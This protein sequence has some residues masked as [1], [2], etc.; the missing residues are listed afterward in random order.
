VFF[1]VLTFI[2]AA[3]TLRTRPERPTKSSS[4]NCA[5]LPGER[6]L[7]FLNHEVRRKIGRTS[8]AWAPP[9][10]FDAGPSAKIC[11]LRTRPLRMPTARDQSVESARKD[12]L[13]LRD[14]SQCHAS[15]GGFRHTVS[16]LRSRALSTSEANGCSRS[17]VTTF[18][19]TRSTT[20]RTLMLRRTSSASSIHLTSPAAA[21]HRRM[22][23]ASAVPLRAA[24]FDMQAV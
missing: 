13:T 5:A 4:R 6:G 22:F 20:A 15:R 2:Y 7:W 12:L 8:G 17:P 3:E 23:S 14:R 9:N 11:A 18:A 16:D 10:R 24:F 1:D 19:A 21:M